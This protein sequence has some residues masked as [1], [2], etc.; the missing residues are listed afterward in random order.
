M[1]EKHI[2][3]L[4]CLYLFIPKSSPKAIYDYK[5]DS[6][7]PLT[8][9]PIF[10]ADFENWAEEEEKE[11]IKRDDYYYDYSSNSGSGSGSS[12]ADACY[13]VAPEDS[14]GTVSEETFLDF[15]AYYGDY[16]DYTADNDCDLEWCQVLV[17]KL[18]Y[19]LFLIH[20]I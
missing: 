2:L 20:E 12:S 4:F 17:F 11:R 7:Q 1:K 5:R 15:S 6:F 13:D 16:M 18:K 10:D 3:L 8:P 19:Y 14:T 9:K